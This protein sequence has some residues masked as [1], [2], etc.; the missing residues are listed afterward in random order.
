MRYEMKTNSD[1]ARNINVLYYILW[2]GANMNCVKMC[3]TIYGFHEV[4][5]N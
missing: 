4:S 2:T 1:C 3:L 5:V